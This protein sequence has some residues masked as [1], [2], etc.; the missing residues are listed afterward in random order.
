MEHEPL[1]N[2]PASAAAAG[3]LAMSL[4]QSLDPQNAFPVEPIIVQDLLG[5]DLQM[6]QDKGKGSS[7]IPFVNDYASNTGHGAS[8]SSRYPKNNY[9]GASSSSQTH[10]LPL[11]S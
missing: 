9:S 4:S 1:S 3:K 7:A 11:K 2:L 6:G 5:D 10:Q 8:S